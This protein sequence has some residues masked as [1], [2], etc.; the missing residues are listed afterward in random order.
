MKEPNMNSNK[1]IMSPE[2]KKEESIIANNSGE[3]AVNVSLIN[4]I[5]LTLELVIEENKNSS[6]YEDM[7]IKQKNMSFTSKAPPSIKLEKYIERILY[8][9]EAEES[10]FI[11]A[12][13]YIDRISKISNVILTPYN[14]HKFIFVSVLI[15]IK[16]N[17]DIIYKLDYYSLISGMSINEL[18][19]LEIDFVVLLKFKLYINK[20]EY[21]NYKLLIDN[22][23]VDDINDED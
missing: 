17:E 16:Y 1:I 2:D 11:I 18:K 9:T 7:L 5:K 22:A 20:L 19:Q 21:N 23:D 3:K 8:Y 13:I 10:T 15:A 6:N 12:L 4:K 14:V